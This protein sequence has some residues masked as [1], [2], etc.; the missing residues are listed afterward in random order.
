MALE[1][2]QDRMKVFRQI[3]RFDDRAHLCF[4]IINKRKNVDINS[5]M[6]KVRHSIQYAKRLGSFV[7]FELHLV[8]EHHNTVPPME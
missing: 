1:S 2:F 6:K 5:D 3:N 8:A 7:V 4:K